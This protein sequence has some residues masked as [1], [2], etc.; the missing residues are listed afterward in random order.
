MPHAPSA[1]ILQEFERLIRSDP[2][3]RGL[4]S[5]EPPF[6][7]LCQGHLSGAAHELADKCERA[8][9]VTGFFVPH[10]TPAAAETDGPPGAVLLA[11][12]LLA[13]GIDTVVV[14][15]EN[16][17]SAVAATARASGYP[18]SRVL[19]APLIAAAWI[20]D[21]LRE[22][23]CDGLTH[24]ISVERVGPSHSQ[25]S[26]MQQVRPRPRALQPLVDDFRARVPSDCWNRCHNMRGNIID[27]HTGDLHLLFERLA[28]HCPRARTIGIGDGAN[29]IG[30]G[31][32]P[33]EELWPRLRGEHACRIPCRI[34]AHWN[35]LAGTSNWGA[36]ALA[37]A[38]ALLRG[39][40]PLLEDWTSARHLAVLEHLVSQGPAVD[41]VT[42]RQNPT[43]DGLSFAAYIEPW[44]CMRRA[45][46]LAC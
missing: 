21:W 35:I 36:Y 6:S 26:L 44:D 43:V 3:R 12:V 1:S 33:W 18:A 38:V 5:A 24:L 32:I 4:M 15:D 11:A 41:G 22:A 16:C 31:T 30:M 2:A 23:A 25:D 9:I 10:A 42:G 40:T 7:L 46:G 8:A 14:T 37:A 45:L 39:Q 28:H 34:A 27:D 29:E 17:H 19:A 20:E 13:S